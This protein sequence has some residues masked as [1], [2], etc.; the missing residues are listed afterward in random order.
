MVKAL[1]KMKILK[2]RGKGKI[3]FLAIFKGQKVNYV[4]VLLLHRW[5]SSLPGSVRACIRQVWLL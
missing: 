5:L 1:L 2:S 3:R 4:F